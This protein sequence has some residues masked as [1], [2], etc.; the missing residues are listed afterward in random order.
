M[1]RYEAQVCRRAGRVLAVSDADAAALR[2]LVPGLDVTIV[3]NGIDT[4]AYRPKVHR[5]RKDQIGD[6]RPES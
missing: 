4:R 5:P 6:W 1:R 3:P 2:K